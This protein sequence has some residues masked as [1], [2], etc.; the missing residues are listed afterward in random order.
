MSSIR[1]TLQAAG[2]APSKARGQNFLRSSATARRLVAA[3]GVTAADAVV[4][5]GPGLG[6]LT[7]P[8]AAV[9]RRVVAIEV[10]R[11]LVRWLASQELPATVEVLHQDVMQ[12]DLG[13]LARTLGPPVML[14][15][16]LPY[17]LSGR[18]LGALLGPRNPF[19][20]MALM[21]QSEVAERVLAEPGSPAYGPLAVWSRLWMPARR[22]LSLG[23]GE[24]EPEPQVRST[25]L[26]FAPRRPAPQVDPG[27][28][29][30]LVRTAFQQRRK[31]LRGALRR[32]FPAADRALRRAGI[33]GL[34]RAE[35]LSEEEFVRLAGA[36]AD[37]EARG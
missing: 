35:T 13:G 19:R 16:N 2:L 18:L 6:Q 5:V 33:E 23:R 20:G 26:L 17:S 14:V 22:A 11:G 7:R 9:A 8:L 37:P 1:D 25:F 29:R 31:G 12:A 32:E 28:L 36:I 27:L 15:G 10:D 34:R 30:R 24:F 21:L 3:A 4:E